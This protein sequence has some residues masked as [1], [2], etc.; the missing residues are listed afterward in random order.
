MKE[1]IFE[2]L[3]AALFAGSL[4]NMLFAGGFGMTE[5]VRMAAKPNNLA[6]TAGLVT[7]FSGVL[8]GV[9][10]VAFAGITGARIAL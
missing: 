3:S 7:V 9:Y 4:Q 6:R 2:T 1:L 5:A 10:L 8:A